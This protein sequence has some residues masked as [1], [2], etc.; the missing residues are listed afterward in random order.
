MPSTEGVPS[1][2]SLSHIISGSVPAR[3]W[4]P[5]AFSNSACMPLQV[6]AAVRGE[7]G[8]AVLALLA[9]PEADAPDARDA[10]VPREHLERLRL[11]DADEL[12]G[13]GAVPDVVPVPVGEEVRGRAVDE[14]EPLRGDRLPVLRRDALAHDA[15]GDRGEL[16]VD[17]LD[18]LRVDPLAYLLDEIVTAV[19]LDEALQVGRHPL[20]LSPARTEPACAGA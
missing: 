6:P 14:L 13:L 3:R 7:E 5:V 9:V 12:R 4:S 16:V 10:R 20:L 18:P 8:A 1:W 17:V 11:R 2:S 19:R 15:A